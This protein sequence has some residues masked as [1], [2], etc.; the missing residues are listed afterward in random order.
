MSSSKNQ[1]VLITGAN[2]GMGYLAALQLAKL[3]GYNVLVGARS[4]QKGQ[5][6]VKKIEGKSPQSK[7][8]AILID[9]NSDESIRTAVKDIESKFGRLDVLV[10]FFWPCVSVIMMITLG[11]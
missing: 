1:V 5:D 3:P 8:E 2:Q 7:V 9:V 10:V 6:A 11:I 4:V